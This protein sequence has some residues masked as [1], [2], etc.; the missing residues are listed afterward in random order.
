M[1]K[2]T[3]ALGFLLSFYTNPWIE[4]AGYQKSF[5]AMA[6][7]SGGFILFW[8]PFYL[9][10]NHIRKAT[11]RWNFVKELAHW[12]DDREVGE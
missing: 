2:Y 12:H 11:W 6:G 7:I 10:G 8:V 4:K 5:G 3:A 1:P 9:W